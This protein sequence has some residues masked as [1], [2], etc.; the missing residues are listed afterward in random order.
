MWK[1]PGALGVY[2][3]LS[4]RT[5]QRAVGGVGAQRTTGRTALLGKEGWAGPGVDIPQWSLSI[6]PGKILPCILSAKSRRLGLAC[7]VSA[8][9]TNGET[10]ALR[11]K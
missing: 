7:L 4:S 10:E 5:E 2:K 1:H 9:S 3:D 11:R 8:C 6:V